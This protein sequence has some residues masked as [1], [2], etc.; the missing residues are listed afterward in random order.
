M[1]YDHLRDPAMCFC[2]TS[3]TNTLAQ[4]VA[5]QGRAGCNS[6]DCKKNAIKISKGELRL[7]TWVVNT[8]DPDHS[9]Y[10]WKH[11]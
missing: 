2:T 1:D 3:L 11:W 10:K 7:G 6:T 4:E 8:K 9:S 5:K